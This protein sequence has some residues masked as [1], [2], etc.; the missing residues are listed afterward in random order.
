MSLRIYTDENVS[1]A[2][3]KGLR[4]RHGQVVS[5]PEAGNRQFSDEAQLEYAATM[6]AVLFTH[7]EDFLSIAKQWRV[8]GKEH[9][10]II[11]VHQGS[12]SVGECIRRLKDVADTFDPEDMRNYVEYL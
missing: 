2:I 11:Y 1:S 8:Q 4:Q 6:R 10:G 7:D 9:W 5:A 3:V 12:L